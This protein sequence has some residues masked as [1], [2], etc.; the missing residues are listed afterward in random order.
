MADTLQ[1]QYRVFC[2][3]DNRYEYVWLP[4]TSPAP[5][6]CPVNGAHTII[7]GRTA[8]VERYVLSP[9]TGSSTT[10]LDRELNTEPS[11]PANGDQYIIGSSPTGLWTGHANQIARWDAETNAW[12]FIT[13]EPGSVFFVSNEN[14]YYRYTGSGWDIFR[15]LA[16]VGGTVGSSYAEVTSLAQKTGSTWGTL[17]SVT[18][19]PVDANSTFQVHFDVSIGISVSNDRIVDFRLMAGPTGSE[20]QRRGT[21]IQTDN[22][23]KA[24]G[25]ALTHS[26]S[27][28]N[29][30]EHT[31]RIEWRIRSGSG[32]A[33]IAPLVDVGQHA[34]L[35]VTEMKG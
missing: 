16:G 5:T 13:P 24:S 18:R 25:G 8:N 9:V 11:S 19:T 32:T 6:T 27:A 1:C 22:I 12:L 15:P 4:S 14:Q 34:S 30:N 33:S 35:L 26:M 21:Y 3:T 17:L 28:S 31:F 29:V 2:Q 7:A 23:D 20:T 10:I